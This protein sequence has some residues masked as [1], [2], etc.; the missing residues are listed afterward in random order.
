[1]LLI[2][3]YILPEKTDSLQIDTSLNALLQIRHMRVELS[4]LMCDFFQYMDAV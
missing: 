4:I 1:M 2:P 3:V